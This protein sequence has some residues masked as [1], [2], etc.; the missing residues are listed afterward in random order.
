MHSQ[1][2]KKATEQEAVLRDGSRVSIRPIRASDAPLV[3]RA[4]ERLTPE[5]RR[6]RFIVAPPSLSEE[7][8]RYLTDID[9]R[10]HDALIALDPVT[11]EAIGEARYVRLLGQPDA[12]EVAAVVDED[13]RG[14]GLATALLT[15]LTARARANG[16]ERYIALVSADNHIVLEAL[17]KLGARHR[18]T[19]GD[20]LELEIDLPGEGMPARLRG[21]LRWAAQG[22]VGLLGALARRL[23]PWPRR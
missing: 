2:T 19:D 8:L 4:Y 11:G 15:E 14:R 7:D 5:S 21:A 10:R 1:A 6:R 17:E 20:E 16:L 12:A 3:A 23:L 9:H 22:Q 13:W 18:N